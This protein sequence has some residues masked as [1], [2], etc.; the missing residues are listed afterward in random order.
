MEFGRNNIIKNMDLFTDHFKENGFV[1]IFETTKKPSKYNFF[2]R[3]IILFNIQ[4][5]IFLHI[6]TIKF[7]EHEIDR[8]N[9]CYLYFELMNIPLTK[10][11]LL[12]GSK[13]CFSEN[14][15]A[16]I[17]NYS[18]GYQ[19]TE[20][21]EFESVVDFYEYF[22]KI[23]EFNS[24]W[25]YDHHLLDIYFFNATAREYQLDEEQ[26][27]ENLLDKIIS[28]IVHADVKNFLSDYYSK[29]KAKL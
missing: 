28:Q 26:D 9:G 1:V 22:S 6:E 29:F 12:K 16:T 2:E 14:N 11:D 27:E 25:N 24:N 23:G 21:C 10:L 19:W 15:D 4:K 18:V 7:N 20:E 3:L 17:F 8:F 5:K 13:T